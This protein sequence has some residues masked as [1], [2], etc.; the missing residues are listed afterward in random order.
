MDEVSGVLTSKTLVADVQA[1]GA[2]YT[3]DGGVG[4]NND[5]DQSTYQD[6]T[7]VFEDSVEPTLTLESDNVDDLPE[8]P[9]DS[10]EASR[11]ST[12]QTKRK[13]M[14]QVSTASLLERER[15]MDRLRNFQPE[16]PGLDDSILSD[17]TS[18]YKSGDPL[19]S[20]PRKTDNVDSPKGSRQRRKDD[21]DRFKTRT[22]R[23]DDLVGG[24]SRESSPAGRLNNH[25]SS[26]ESSPRRSPKSIKQ[27][28]SEEPDRCQMFFL[29]DFL[30]MA[31]DGAK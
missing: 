27:R 11:E 18:G 31:D 2:T 16:V 4:N 6:L 10:R 19:N 17:Q 14:G 3:V 22:I 20:T 28:R 24:S 5:A 23:R 26:A 9:R 1:Q 21:A 29:Y 13:T 8:L 7:D 30:L 12:P 25:G 15:E